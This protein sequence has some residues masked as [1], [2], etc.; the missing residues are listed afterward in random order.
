MKTL[1]LNVEKAT[2]DGIIAEIVENYT[3]LLKP[4]GTESYYDRSNGQISDK[5][6]EEYIDFNE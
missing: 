4:D 5:W 6:V 3:V 1:F 2:N